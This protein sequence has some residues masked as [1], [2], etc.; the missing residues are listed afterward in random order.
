M[1]AVVAVVGMSE[2]GHIDPEVKKG[3]DHDRHY[4]VKCAVLL[5]SCTEIWNNDIHR[6][7]YFV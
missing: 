3:I 7:L 5:Y 2:V 1:V 6:D 4:N